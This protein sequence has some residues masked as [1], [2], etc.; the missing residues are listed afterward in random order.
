MFLKIE[1]LHNDFA[2]EEFSILRKVER[3]TVCSS[4]NQDILCYSKF[5]VSFE[6]AVVFSFWAKIWP[7]DR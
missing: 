4:Y 5:R 3:A 7:G 2:L 6:N 1:K